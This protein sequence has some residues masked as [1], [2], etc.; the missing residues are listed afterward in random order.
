MNVGG[1]VLC[2]PSPL[3][4]LD[5]P[6]LADRGHRALTASGAG[7]KASLFKCLFEYKHKTEAAIIQTIT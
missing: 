6:P 2:P 4:A 3:T 7:N 5:L 1:V